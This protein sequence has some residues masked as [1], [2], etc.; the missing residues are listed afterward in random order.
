MFSLDRV[1][2]GQHGIGVP[3]VTHHSYGSVA[4]LFSGRCNTVRIHIGE[5]DF[6]TIGHQSLRASVSDALRAA[7]DQCK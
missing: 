1:E 6:V 5:Y 7:C 2:H 4:Q 3:H